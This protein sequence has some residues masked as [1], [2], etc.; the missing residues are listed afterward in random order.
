VTGARAPSFEFASSDAVYM[1]SV[2]NSM[3]FDEDGAPH[4]F[5]KY[6]NVVSAEVRGLDL[7]L[8]LV[9]DNHATLTI[10]VRA[11]DFGAAY[12]DMPNR[13]VCDAVAGL[14]QETFARR[15]V[16]GNRAHYVRCL[17]DLQVA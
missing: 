15:P 2:L 4:R 17:R 14:L 8:R 6:W 3:C 9:A 1:K 12:P 5:L 7:F 16:A 13:D 11:V 10:L